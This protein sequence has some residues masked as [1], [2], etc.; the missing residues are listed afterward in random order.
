MSKRAARRNRHRVPPTELEARNAHLWDERAG[1]LHNELSLVEALNA[2]RERADFAC[3]ALRCVVDHVETSV[4]DTCVTVS[5][6]EHAFYIARNT[7]MQLG[8]PRRS[9]PGCRCPWE[10]DARCPVH[11]DV[12]PTVDGGDP[13]KP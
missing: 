4:D 8:E 5:P 6:A 3:E 1:L 10:G 9:E 12:S 2:A 7:L 11:D 13:V